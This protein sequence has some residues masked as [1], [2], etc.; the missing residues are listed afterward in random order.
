MVE[1]PLVFLGGLLGS[2]HCVGMCGGFAVSIGVGADRWQTNVAKQICYTAGRVATYALLGAL[3][4]SVGARLSYSVGSLRVA[5]ASLAIVAG[6][7]LVGVG[8]YHLGLLPRRLSG[9]SSIGC[10]AGKLFG[11]LFHTPHWSSHF[12]A[13]VL[14]GF[15]PCG[16]VYAFLAL[17]ASS[18]GIAAGA[19]QMAAFGMGTAPLMIATG[20]ASRMVSLGA[21]RR[22]LTVAAWCLVFTGVWSLG[23]GYYAYSAATGA[24]SFSSTA[25]CPWCAP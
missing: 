1:L 14:T 7:A 24:A 17:A 11:P 6:V 23:R 25:A 21:R 5:Q 9:R 3:A 20:C 12:A 4:A 15:L 8:A 16:L 19:A 18:G 13:G 22:A 2:T 10:L